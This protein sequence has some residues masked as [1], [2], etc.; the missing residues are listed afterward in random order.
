MRRAWVVDLPKRLK[1]AL[2]E[3]VSEGV[4]EVADLQRRLVPTDTYDLY[5]SIGTSISVDATKGYVVA[6]DT[7]N[8]SD[9]TTLTRRKS[10]KAKRAFYGVLVEY[11][12]KQRP[13]TPFFWPAW[14][15]SI[16]SLRRRFKRMFATAFKRGEIKG[17]VT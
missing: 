12:T 7:G 17:P 1:A 5:H 9:I 6:G 4:E 2:G 16:P 3:A 15:A 13:A 8:T 10:G 11:G 14:R